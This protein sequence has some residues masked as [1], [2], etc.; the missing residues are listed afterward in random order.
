MNLTVSGRRDVA[1]GVIELVLRR[2]DGQA[3]AVWAPGAHIDFIVGP[4]V[5]RQYSLCGS[6]ADRAHYRIA[7]LREEAGRGGSVAIHADAHIGSSFEV[8]GPRNNF[9]LEPADSYLFIAGGIGITPIIPMV[10][11]AVASD[12]DWRLLYGGRQRTSMAYAEELEQLGPRV[13][14]RP[15][16]VD[17][18]LDLDAVLSRCVAG[19]LI[20]CCGPEPLL[21]A[22]EDRCERRQLMSSLRLERFQ[23]RQPVV[24]GVDTDFE[25]ELGSTGQVLSVPADRSILDVLRDYGIDVMS[26]CEEGVCGSCEIPVCSGIPDH[27][28]SILTDEE[29]EAGDRMMVCVSRSRSARLCLDVK[30]GEPR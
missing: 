19:T 29:R 18:L 13:S 20:Y 2:D 21:A 3:L 22:V 14:I 27:R 6:P 15:Q 30:P 24:G 25:V 5:V 9:A 11:A 26:S 16:D 8:A 10:S 17:G 12:A 4:G 28:D 1:T 7:V 23:A